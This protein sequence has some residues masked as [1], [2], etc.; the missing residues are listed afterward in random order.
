[1]SRE[2]LIAAL[3]TLFVEEATSLSRWS[4]VK[5]ARWAAK[6]IYSADPERAQK[7]AEE[8]DA[9]ITKSIPTNIAALCFGLSLGAAAVAWTAARRA[10]VIASA[11]SRVYA[12][13]RGVRLAE[14]NECRVA[15]H[16]QASLALWSAASALR[17]LVGDTAQFNSEDLC[18]HL[19]QIREQAANTQLQAVNVALLAPS[20]LTG[21]AELLAETASRLADAAE[22]V[23]SAAGL[24]TSV[25][26]FTELDESMRAFIQAAVAVSHDLASR[27]TVP[28]FGQA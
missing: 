24:M 16:R 21:S 13:L 17:S 15:E 7:R 20:A 11:L 22:K 19:A 9:L 8:W 3:V 18:A 27:G 12:V 1:V 14:L 2:I 10:T 6:H 28:V 5:L 26:D 4:A 23:S 25:P